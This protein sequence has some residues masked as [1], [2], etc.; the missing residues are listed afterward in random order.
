MNLQHLQS[1]ASEY[2][3]IIEAFSLAKGHQV[4]HDDGSQEFARHYVKAHKGE[5]SLKPTPQNEKD[6]EEFHNNYETKHVRTGFGG[7]GTSVYT[8]KQTGEKFQVN[9]VANGKGFD[10]TD[11]NITKIG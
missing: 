2:A 1:I 7:S 9:R 6:S 4:Y 10:G 3:G 8:H 5:H 11:H